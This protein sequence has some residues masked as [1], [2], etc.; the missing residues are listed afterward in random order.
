MDSLKSDLKQL[1]DGVNKLECQV[2]K[3]DDDLRDQFTT[4]I[5]VGGAA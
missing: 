5:K 4:F 2:Q 3:V 1:E